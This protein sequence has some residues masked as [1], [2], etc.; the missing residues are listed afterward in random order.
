MGKAYSGSWETGAFRNGTFI[1]YDFSHR[2]L[3]GADFS[4]CV[5]KDCDFSGSDLSMAKFANADLYRVDFQGAM[6]YSTDFDGANL[7]RANFDGAFTYGWLLNSTANVAYAN[8][9][10][11]EVERRRR[12]S[13]VEESGVTNA[14]SVPFG[15]IIG[16][17]S[18]LCLADY[19]VGIYG[20]T[21][22]ACD[23]QEI[24]LQKSQIFNRMKRLYRENHYGERA[25]YC[26]YWERYWLTR[27]GYRANPLAGPTN[28]MS[29]AKALRLTGWGYFVE[30][31]AGYGLKPMR[32]MRSIS[33]VFL[34]FLV[35]VELVLVNGWGSLRRLDVGVNGSTIPTPVGAGWGG[36]PSVLDFAVSSALSFDLSH[37]SASGVLEVLAVLYFVT[38]LILF[39]VLFSSTFLLIQVD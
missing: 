32:V 39:A 33:L 8:L 20:F 22:K 2:S 1:G 38:Q 15:S 10:T 5:L 27:S 36:L 31:V 4:G 23:K 16:P 19:Q 26:R 25:I 18:D 30:G 9:L 13:R 17:T 24:A 34:G 12:T 11:F 14:P 35:L 6:L 28:S 37:Y 29:L 3:V 21:F 7:T